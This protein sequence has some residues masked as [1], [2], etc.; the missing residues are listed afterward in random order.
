M[1][2][3]LSLLFTKDDYQA[4]GD[5]ASQSLQIFITGNAVKRWVLKQ[6]AADLSDHIL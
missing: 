2:R 6:E 5:P 4:G 1:L 3:R